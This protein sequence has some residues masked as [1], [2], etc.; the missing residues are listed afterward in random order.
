[1]TEQAEM[2]LAFVDALGAD[3]FDLVGNDTGGGI[4]Q[5]VAAAAP[6]RISS[7]VLTNCDTHDN[8]PPPAFE[9]T[10]EL[11]RSGALAGGLAAL[12]ADPNS[13]RAVLAVGFEDP[14]CLSDSLATG[15]FEPFRDPVRA[16]IVSDCVVGMDPAV[17]VAIESRLA[18]LSAPTLIVWG[19]GDDFF[20]VAWARWL[21]RTIPGTRRRAEI[22]GAKL[23]FPL[24]R[25]D[26]FNAELRA[27]WTT[28]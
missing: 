1:M 15:F 19:T 11:A 6:G 12:A 7:L 21:E 25:G 8:W 13:A 17:T 9:P 18:E 4:A 5:L 24:E 2:V 20:D 23:F 16:E 22:E 27:F 28:T 3:E 26:E 10:R 14:D